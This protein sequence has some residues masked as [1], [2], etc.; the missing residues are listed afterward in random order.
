MLIT[1]E[2]TL[3][4]LLL[5]FAL[6]VVGQDYSC[7]PGKP[8]ALGCCG[9]NGV[10]GMGPDYCAPGNCISECTAKSDCDP[11]WG[12]EWS[13][14]EKCPLNVCCS[15]F[16]FCGTTEEFCGDSKVTKPSC[17][18]TSSNQRTIGYYEGWSTTRA[19]DGMY[20]ENIPA[21]AYTHLNYAFAFI[22]PV[23]FAVA[24]MSDTDKDLWPRFTALKE[25]NPGLKTFISI[26]GWSMNDPDQPTAT[27]FS[28]LAGSSDAQ[29][30]FAKSLITF[31]STYGFDGVD[32]DWEYPVAEERSGKEADYKNYVTFL[33]NLKSALT[34]SGGSYGLTITVPS[35]YWYLRH[36]DIVEINKVIDWFN[37]MTYDLHGTWDST[38]ESLG[39][40]VMAHTNLTEIDLTMDLM[41]R[42]DIP[43]ENIV[44]GLGFYGRSFTLADPSCKTAGCPFS[45]GG[46]AGECTNSV[47]TL[48]FVEINRLIEAGAT[49]TL[50]KDAAVQIVTW[51]N[52]QWVSYDD[53]E[54]FKMKLDYANSLCLGG[55]MIWASSTDDSLGTAAAAL[56]KS[57]GHLALSLKAVDKSADTFSQCTWGACA[58]EGET[59]CDGDLSAAQYASGKGK[60]NAGF[61]NDCPKGQVRPYCCPKNDV[62]TC[63]WR[64]HGINCSNEKCEEGEVE[65]TTHVG[66]CF[67]GHT[68]LCCSRT[69]SDSAIGTCKWEGASPVCS[70]PFSSYGCDDDRQEL[71]YSNY[72]AGGE[73]YCFTGHKSMCCTKPVVF[74]GCKWY[75]NSHWYA[76]WTCDAGCPSGKMA[77]ATDPT[78]CSKGSQYFCCDNPVKIPDKP[79]VKLDFCYSTDGDFVEA[80]EK[81]DAAEDSDDYLE[82]WWYEDECFSIPNKGD[83]SKQNQRRD[84][85]ADVDV[86]GLHRSQIAKIFLDEGSVLEVPLSSPWVQDL[87]H[88][89]TAAASSGWR[90]DRGQ[91]QGDNNSTLE[92]RNG[93]R[94]SKICRPDKTVI[95]TFSSSP[96]PGVGKLTPS[97][98]V[99]NLGTTGICF[100]ATLVTTAHSQLAQ[101]LK[102]VVEHVTELQTPKAFMNSL[103]A[104]V[105]PSGTTGFNLRYNAET[106]FG[107]NGYFDYTL[108]GLG[109]DGD[110]PNIDPNTKISA[111]FYKVL[112]STDFKENLQLLTAKENSLKAAIWGLYT[113]INADTKWAK[114]SPTTQLDV[115]WR[116]KTVVDYL[117]QQDVQTSLEVTRDKMLA[118][119]AAMDR[120]LPN[121]ITVGAGLSL[122]DAMDTWYR[123]H[124]QTMTANLVAYVQR[125]LP[126]MIT[127]WQS[128]A[129]QNLHGALNAAA[130]VAD[131]VDFQNNAGAYL[132]I[133]TAFM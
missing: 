75:S 76:P 49:V 120:V 67:A 6:L 51:D 24:P 116:L 18:G 87:L 45:G 82:L 4:A 66:G 102:T 59:K 127:F 22:D 65:V 29:D 121:F 96:Y 14:A 89:S 56:S 55:S 92:E 84:L 129:G 46:A 90:P 11:G 130:I 108:K 91:Q 119:F 36:F 42:N 122:E 17:K 53:A 13:S 1:K 32:I 47:G 60:G 68:R 85:I 123:D 12:S 63:Q 9:T 94:F 39:P 7:G 95:N 80:T 114:M 30:K 133:S 38:I 128:P 111:F 105:L 10:C 57:T 101:G 5:S 110:F 131:L 33:K 112:G 124:F 28:D 107:K 79:D 64:G 41:W 118:I 71:T 25:L 37:V 62:P 43:P 78:S 61:Y 103:L 58:K 44:L 97:R 34:A 21:G 40:K 106:I 125:R 19:C 77:L 86:E 20:P 52:D 54:T 93:S 35:S 115:M 23:S 88:L 8:C 132:A 81:D 126:D 72:G 2:S 16:G 109:I 73:Q 98:L 83:P 3:A 26:G 100:G 99:Y 70:A 69:S 27:T 50:D 117:N 104:H 15:K 74:E 113:N 48:S 31:M